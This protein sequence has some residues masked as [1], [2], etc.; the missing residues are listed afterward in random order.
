MLNKRKKEDSRI[1]T[2]K[3]DLLYKKHLQGAYVRIGG[4]LAMWVFLLSAFGFHIIPLETFLNGTFC[5][6]Y[7]ILFNPPMLFA[8]KRVK[9]V[10]IYNLFSFS[11]NI[12]EIIGYTGIIYFLGGIKASF[13]TLQYAVLIMF[14]GVVSPRRTPF[15]MATVSS[16][17]YASVVLLDYLGVIPHQNALTPFVY[18][19]KTQ[20]MI[21]LV[22]I[23]YLYIIAFTSS[24]IG[25]RLKQRRE[26]LMES[27]RRYREHIEN[28]GDIIYVLDERKRIKYVN[29][30]FEKLLGISQDQLRRKK[31]HDIAS[32]ESFSASQA[33]VRRQKGA[34]K[35]D[36]FEVR[37]KDTQGV[38]RTIE[39]QENLVWEGDSI[40]EINGMG[41]DTTE[42]KK[43][44]EQLIRSQ[45]M[46]AIVSLSSGIAHNFNNILVG[47]M[48]Y[49]EL[50]LS[51]RQ[52][53]DPDYKPLETIHE[54][55][56][57][58][59]ELTKQLL[60]TVREGKYEP[61]MANINDVVEKTLPLVT[62]TFDKS[63]EIKTLLNKD[64]NV[65][66]GD[67][68]LLEQCVLNLCINARD[69]MPR[70]G[71]LIIETYSKYL[72]DD[73]L[74]T[75]VGAQEGEHTV[76]SIT[77]TGTGIDPEIVN[78]IFDPFFTTKADTGGIGMGLSTVYGIVK[79]HKGVITV[80][81]ELEKGTTFRL[82][83]PVAEGKPV[84]PSER[85]E[86][87]SADGQGTILIIDDE[88]E[89]REIWE[90]F[91]RGKGYTVITAKNGQEGIDIFR[92]EKDEIDLVV[93]DLVMPVKSGK[94]VL[95]TLREIRSDVKVIGCSGYSENGLAK[96]FV[97]A[98][99]DFFI[100]KPVRLAE[101][102]DK[103]AVLLKR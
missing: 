65:L 2:E 4:S 27:E 25:S 71:Q 44:E 23:G 13:L 54:A 32:L 24:Y 67:A 68:G 57:R 39:F 86:G 41:R 36:L 12:L 85:K 10:K 66:N 38:V 45:K 60:N 70:G 95:K 30:T 3:L 20:I 53:D 94:E 52:K 51:R 69:A 16:I 73:F 18:D 63:I 33:A 97:A 98:G 76:L 34:E 61:S 49:S 29:K 11:I 56:I 72:D 9:R 42:K 35:T 103:I 15:V 21:V 100:Q 48:G 19:L 5:I 79:K 84:G 7:L 37:F 26:D 75:H 14:V 82:Y 93:I 80:Y 40:R 99:L 31:F 102:A 77:D 22:I 83:F 90:V 74:R 89:V 50:L 55:S 88:P 59:S 78:R 92:G 58:A 28:I 96:E 47:I 17:C 87:A 64:T 62:G 101:F 1:Q 91:L 8:L 6:A 46:E 43:L 81:S